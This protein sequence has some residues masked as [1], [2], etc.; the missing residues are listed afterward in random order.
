[1]GS[2]RT[3]QPGEDLGDIHTGT[4]AHKHPYIGCSHTITVAGW[5][6]VAFNHFCTGIA[7]HFFQALGDAGRAG[8]DCLIILSVMLFP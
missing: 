1:M 7:S 3:P 6:A 5:L 2:G 8:D 4:R